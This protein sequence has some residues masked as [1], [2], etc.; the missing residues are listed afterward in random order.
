MYHAVATQATP[1][2]IEDIPRYGI[3]QG[4]LGNENNRNRD[5]LSSL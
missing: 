3:S 1:W 2:L 5:Q 4:R